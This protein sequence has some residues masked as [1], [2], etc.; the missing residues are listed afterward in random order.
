VLEKFVDR[1][2]F[3]GTRLER[4]NVIRF[5]L[6]A[7]NCIN[8]TVSDIN[9]VKDPLM[10]TWGARYVLTNSET[11]KRYVCIQDVCDE[12]N[13]HIGYHIF[14][15]KDRSDNLDPIWIPILDNGSDHVTRISTLIGLS[16]ER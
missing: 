12:K 16:F 5:L 7:C 13:Y 3:L 4:D 14:C 10:F 15:V 6:S 8:I 1:L 9:I 11:L 2:V